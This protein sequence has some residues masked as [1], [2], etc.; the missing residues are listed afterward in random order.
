MNYTTT[1]SFSLSSLQKHTPLGALIFLSCFLFGINSLTAQTADFTSDIT[2]DCNTATVQFSDQSTGA[3]S[4]LWNLG[5][6]NTSTLQNPSATYLTP[7]TYTVSLTINGGCAGCTETKTDYITVHAPPTV[8]FSAGDTV[9]CAPYVVAFTDAS[10][11][12]GSGTIVSWD[13]D[14]G[15]GVLSTDQNPTHVYTFANT[16]DVTLSVTDNFGCQSN[17]S[18]LNYIETFHSPTAGFSLDAGLG[19]DVPHTVNF[20]DESIIPSLPPPPG[21][22]VS[23][24][25]DFGDGN[26][27]TSASPSHTYTSFGSYTVTL[28]VTSADGCTDTLTMADA[29]VIVNDQ[30]G[31]TQSST[32][33][34]PGDAVSFTDT[35]SNATAWSW[36]FGDGT[37]STD[38]NPTHIYTTSGTY[39]VALSVTFA[40]GC[41]KTYTETAAVTVFPD[42]TASFSPD[43]TDACSVPFTVNFTNSV[44]AAS[45]LWDF[46]DGNTSTDAN[47]SHTYT[48]PG[49]YDVSLTVTSADGCTHTLT[50][51]ELIQI[52]EPQAVIT[53]DVW[54]GCVPLAVS[55]TDNSTSTTPIT[56]W[57]W[58]FGDG[59]TSTAQNPSNTFT[60]D[61]QY[62][63]TLTVTN[64]EGCTSTRT[65]PAFIHAGDEPVTNFTIG[66]GDSCRITPVNF[67]NL[68]TNID[69]SLWDFGDGGTS[70]QNSPTYTYS[71]VGTFDVTL[72]TYHHGCPNTVTI[73]N[74]VQILPPDAGFTIDNNVECDFPADVVFTNTSTDATSYLWRFGDGNTST[75]T[76]PSHTYVNPGSYTVWLIAMRSN[77]NCVDSMS[78][79]VHVS[80]SIPGFTVDSD[81]GC[82]PLVATFTDTSFTTGT[83]VAWDWDF[84][85]G[86]TS[87]DQNP[88]HTYDLPGVFTVTLTI[89]EEHG[90]TETITKINYI[91]TEGPIVNFSSS[92]P[93]V[94]LGNTI[95]FTDLTVGTTG[96]TNWLWDFGDG[97]TS[98]DQNPTHTYTS[99]GTYTVSL[100]VDDAFGCDRSHTET[101]FVVVTNPIAD[102]STSDTIY[103][104]GMTIGFQNNSTG[105]G[106]SYLWDFGDGTT[107]TATS[108]THTY[109]ADGTYAVSLTVTDSYGC[110]DVFTA[111]VQNVTPNADFTAAATVL[112]CAP[113]SA[114]F[115][116]NSSSDINQWFWQ[117]GDGGVSLLENPS[118]L[119]AAPGTY[120]VTLIAFSAGGCT[121][122]IVK[123]SFITVDGPIG[124]FTYTPDS[125]CINTDVMFVADTSNVSNITWDFGDG[126]TTNVMEDSIT[127]TY[128]TVGIFY[129]QLIL[130]NSNGCVFTYTN[131]SIITSSD[132]IADFIG[133][134]SLICFGGTVDFT[135]LSSLTDA[136]YPITQWDWDFGNGDTDTLQNS[137]STYNTPGSYDVSLA[138]ETSFGCKDTMVKPLYINVIDTDIAAGFIPSSTVLCPGDPITFTDTTNTT[139]GSVISWN[140]DFGDGSTSTA[141]NGAHAFSTGGDYTITLVAGDSLCL[142]TST[143]NINVVQLNADF[144]ADDTCNFR[145]LSTNFTDQSTGDSTIVSWQWDFGYN[146][147]TS[148][149]QNPSHTFD[150][151]A[152]Y[153]ITLIVTDT[154]GCSDTLTRPAY[155]EAKNNYPIGVNDTTTAIEDNGPITITVVDDDS[156]PDGDSLIVSSIPTPPANGT[157]TVNPDGTISYEPD[158]DFFGMD[159]LQYIVCDDRDPLCDTAWIFVYVSPVDDPPVLNPQTTDITTPEDNPTTFCLDLIN[160][161]APLDPIT[162]ITQVAGY[163][164]FGSITI[165]NDSCFTYS[166]SLHYYG[167]DTVMVYICDSTGNCD[168]SAIAIDVTPVNDPPIASNDTTTTDEDTPIDINILSNDDDPVEDDSLITTS[169]ITQPVNGTVSINPD[170]T[171]NYDPDPHFF[172]I[173][174][175]QYTMCDDG[176]PMAE[177]DDAWVFITIDPVDDAPILTSSTTNLTTPEDNPIS[178]C[179]DLINLDNPL[180][181][182]TGI[183]QS[184]GPSFGSVTID[185]DSC[186]TY[187]PNLHY[188]GSDAVSFYICD[189]TGNCDTT[190]ISIDVTPVNDPPIASND[191][192]TT[193]EDTPIDINI[194]GNDDDPVEDDSLITTSIITGPVNGTASINPDG[195]I[196][197]D[198]NPDFF[199]IDSLHY[200]MCDDGTPIAECDDAWVFITVD[201]VDDAPVITP[202]TASLTTP[203]D[204]PLTVALTVTNPDFPLDA[205]TSITPIGGTTLFGTVTIIDDT[206]FTYTPNLHYYGPDTVAVYVCD[207]TGNCDTA[208]VAIDVT[209][210]NDP[211]I[212]VNDTTQTLVDIP[213][214]IDVLG[215]DS[216][217]VEGDSLITNLVLT[218][219]LNGTASI[220]P[221]GTINYVPDPGYHGLDS[222]Q[223]IM[224]DDGT[225][226]LCDTAWVLITI[227][228][229]NPPVAVNDSI[230]VTEDTPIDYPILTN[231]SDPNPGD[232]IFPTNIITDPVHGTASINPDG[233]INYVPATN[234]FGYDS[235]QYVIC[236]DGTPVMCDTAWLLISVDDVDDDPVVIPSDTAITLPEDSVHM[237]C[238][239]VFNFDAPMD[240]ITASN[241][242]GYPQNGIIPFVNDS[243]TNYIPNPDYFGPDTIIILAC[244]LS[245][246]C[247]T[248]TVYV[249]VTPVNDP[250]TAVND[251]TSTDEDVSID[252]PVLNNDHNQYETD[253]IFVTNVSVAPVNGTATVNPDGSI[254]YDPFTGFFGID[255]L[256]YTI[257]DDQVP[258]LCT[259]AWAFITIDS[260]DYLPVA[261][262]DTVTVYEG[263]VNAIIQPLLNDTDANGDSTISILAINPTPVHGTISLNPDSTFSYTP[264]PNFFGIDSLQY[265]IVD[266]QGNT[267]TAWVL[268]NVLG[269]DD[270]PVAS[271]D[272]VW[273]SEDDGAV[274]IPILANDYDIDGDSLLISSVSPLPQNG[275]A[276]VN[277]NGTISYTPDPNFHGVDSLMYVITDDYATGSSDTAWVFIYVASVND[278]IIAVN[279]TT[280]TDEDTPVVID[281]LVNDSD[282][283]DGDSLMVTNILIGA[284]NGNVVINPDGTTTYTPNPNFAGV[285]S[286]TYIVTDT[287]NPA[288]DDTAVVYITINPVND[289]PVAVDDAVTTDEDTP[290]TISVLDNDDDPIDGDS[291]MTSSILVGPTNG[292]VVINPDGTTTYTPNPNYNGTDTFTYVITDVNGLTDTAVVVITIDP[293]ND[294]PVAVDN[295]TT[296]DEDTPV[297]ID[298]LANDDD[299]DGD[300]ISTTSI[301][302]GPANGSVVINPDGTTTYTP[303][304]NY[305]GTDTFTYV[306][307][308]TDGLTDTAIVV[309]TITPSNDPP[310]AVDNA[311]TTDEDTPVTIDV[312]ANDSDV[313]GDSIFT[314]SILV[315]PTNGNVVINPDGTT[316]YTP[317]P[318]YTGTDTFTYVITD[319]H[320]LTDTAVVVVTIDPVNDPPV[321]LDNASTTDEDT[322]VTIDV[323]GNDSDVDGDTISTASILVGPTNGS[324]VIN[325]D[326]T[327]TYTPNPNYTGTDTFT[328]VITDTDGLTDTAVVVVT[329]DPVNDPPVAVDNAGTTDEDTPIT[330]DV[331]ANDDDVD[332]DSIFTSS[333]LVGPANGS[334]V[335]NPDGT[336]TYTPDPNYTGTDTFTYVITATDGLTDTAIVVITIDP[337]NDPPVAVDNAS[338]TDEDT[339]VTIDV[340][341]N[342][343]DVDGDTISTATILVG[344]TNGSVVINPDGTTTYTPNPNY[345]GTD[346][347]TYVI[348]DTDG[349]TDTA[350]VVVTIDPANDPPVA[351]DDATTTDEDTPVTIDVL[352]NDSDVDGDSISTASILAGPTNGSVVINPDGTTTYTPNPNYNGTDTFTYVITDIHGLTDTAVVVITIDPVNDPPVAVDNASTTD[353]DTPVT[354]DVLANDDDVD[355]DSISTTSVLVGPTNGSVVINPDGTTTYTPNANYTGTDTFTYVITATDGL[356]DTAVVVVTINPSNDPPVAVDN[357]TTTDEDTP[358]TIDV[359]ANDSDVDGDSISTASILVGPTN[360]SVVINPD[361]T[362]TYTPD[363]NYN[364]T[365]TFTYVITDIHGLTDTAVVVITIDPV[366]DPPVAV[367]NAATTDE[368]TPVVI[369]VLANDDD[370]DGDSISTT[371]ILV[372]PTNGSVVINPDGTTTY[373]PNPHY[374]GTDTFTYV[375]TATDGLMD[376]AVV[377]VTIDPS[378]DPPVATDD[379]VSTDEDTP[380]VIDV[381]VNDSDVDGDSIMVG[382][383]LSNPTNGVLTTNPD[384]TL[385][386][387]PDPNFTGTD[388]FTYIVRDTDGLI[389]TAVVV[390]TV[391]PSNDP[392]VAVD[393]ATTT[394][395]DTPVTIDILANDYDI[396]GDTV[397]LGAILSGPSNGTL[398]TNPD[399]TVTYTPDPNF[400]GTD[401]FTYI[402]RDPDGLID[403]AVV[404]ITVDPSNDPP[405]AVNDTTV[406]D[407]DTPVVIDILADDYDVDGDSIALHGLLS[408]PSN[409]SLG[410]NPDGTITYTP[411]PNFT[412]SD[413]FSYIIVDEDGL[414]DTA[415]VL[416]SVNP[417]NDPPVAVN[418][419]A[420][421]DE[422]TPVVIDVLA[423]DDDVD[424]DSISTTSIH[425]APNNGTASINPDGT[426]TYTPNANYTGSD[427]FTYIITDENGDTDTAVVVVTIDPSNDPPVAVNDTVTTDLNTAITIDALANDSDPI[428]GDSL[429]MTTIL[430]GANNG[431]TS[432]NPDGTV[433]YTP[434]NGFTGIDSLEYL[435]CDNGSPSQCTNAWIFITVN[436]TNTP[437]VAHNDINNTLVNTPVTGSVLQNDDDDNGTGNLTA[438]LVTSPSNGTI[439]WNPDGTYTYVPNTDFVGTDCFDYFITDEDGLIDTATICI[440]VTDPAADPPVANDDYTVTYVDTPIPGNVMHNDF[441]VDGDLL[442]VGTTLISGPQNGTVSMNPDG[443]FIYTPD[444]G[445]VGIDTFTYVLF[446]SQA[447]GASDTAT[448]IILV[449]DT[450]NGTTNLPPFAG[451]DANIT[452]VNTP[453]TG[454][455]LPNDI[456]LDGTTLTVNQTPIVQPAHGTVTIDAN[457]NYTYT[458][459]PDYTGPDFFVYEVCD[460]GTPQ[461]CRQATVYITVLP[462]N[463]V[464]PV[465]YL[466]FTAELEG[467]DAFLNWITATEIN[468]DYFAI[469]RSTDGISFERVGVENAA[470]TTTE[471]TSYLFID[472]NVTNLGTERVYYRLKQV[473]FDGTF[474]Y[475][476]TIELTLPQIEE[477]IQSNVYPNP[478]SDYVYVTAQTQEAT[479]LKIKLV[480]MS[481]QLVWEY[482]TAEAS[483]ATQVEIPLEQF[484]RGMYFIQ[485]VSP[486][487]TQTHK[488]IVE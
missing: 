36:D 158:P 454:A 363:P 205:V 18:Q 207:S 429:M 1:V 104:T 148:T 424:G 280:V 465:E 427:I 235:L 8:D 423:N 146:N 64:A 184:A 373:T 262:N 67:T 268:I 323:L 46:G 105:D 92:S 85:D 12:A 139:Y 276:V 383:I 324:V 31:F 473:D 165:D 446:E 13:W 123:P 402:V 41:V 411:N 98:T 82:A 250:P 272:T 107:S 309:V 182:I 320:G 45:Y 432:I 178:F 451:D 397:M 118:N 221:D 360:G 188:N 335:I 201:P 166:P 11:A 331:L 24:S 9:G 314:S 218:D 460:N 95:T 38:Q 65:F 100:T 477:E 395:E 459:N 367:D 27:S 434:D 244:D 281:V 185:N 301:L 315:G 476:N 71:T 233:T 311:S 84:G 342:D 160:V 60:A 379:A 364:G 77:G 42:I 227:N 102:F 413:S 260:V 279:D 441:D 215:S 302:V 21:V 392:P 231:D 478:A 393:N 20:S 120:D 258:S 344:P 30:P 211:P 303:N 359:L 58:D 131:D 438:N 230:A 340:L 372:G 53:S 486:R 405:V 418:D 109:G 299:V 419:A 99:D 292:S 89:T 232:I 145:P 237:V 463:A 408:P 81:S 275:T 433:T 371:N 263:D 390:I 86:N 374:T 130:E 70:T 94:C 425:V 240:Q 149:T 448:V 217:P 375:I 343:S 181:P 69:S 153:D 248:A 192:T 456:D 33:A 338:T 291:I 47:P 307:T 370:V 246:D 138:I 440:D 234:Y 112:G 439:T 412:G 169:I 471:S 203:E 72:T 475:S 317:D 274:A 206:T 76:S 294:P 436:A 242:A 482:K 175:L 297:T 150:S 284:T 161:D 212:A 79:M 49:L 346:T 286:F 261:N 352:L 298:V 7:G 210:V 325:P 410:I 159:S 34:C 213:I 270:P 63:V 285:D 48:A 422:D 155:V 52:I 14:F 290:I 333:I 384:G 430:V 388:T 87:T 455:I 330:I 247:D 74:G 10:T 140:W 417:D 358:V 117:F 305:T 174:S 267:D 483:T 228:L 190:T 32:T 339:P 382:A 269:T 170:G 271:N 224:C 186:F 366:N 222:L 329:I 171:I 6:G 199:G 226:N 23:W 196:N 96:L 300:S 403:T 62:D 78:R 283:I 406:T 167:P 461:E 391:D 306:I 389:D 453:V 449:L 110:T 289:P 253:S 209:P 88:T 66:Q 293:V 484:A 354:I 351:V 310:V 256:E 288:L 208:V 173:D 73:G 488:L 452:D 113:E 236:D 5:N 377:V 318:N 431:M 334:V 264:N 467:R 2:S 142:D 229:N 143:F 396:D 191:T 119:Y 265:V 381:L 485:V 394:D 322:P 111:D 480:N 398:T 183:M 134:D 25:W 450:P 51:D 350:V 332:G 404:T 356:T 225:P 319:I 223:Y 163:P 220:N 409:G 135:D 54:N 17:F 37:T 277:P 15:D 194:L 35:S 75:A 466:A 442:L 304:A 295:A 273:I 168:T 61:G 399:G 245:G 187:T 328:Y 56:S 308:A 415:V 162:G 341:G 287:G 124:N 239:D 116:D 127:H 380:V 282:P 28:V 202:S 266:P 126:T 40:N 93:N 179:L 198:P 156:D 141:Q 122:T 200:T 378:N 22:I 400:T 157:A 91:D 428:E 249:T 474:S 204:N 345:T 144:M 469:E 447:N 254:H 129:P 3:G 106:I 337:V 464:F 137:T 59:N 462:A 4:W 357:A 68:T 164:S 369:D 321:A 172:G 90:C 16:F 385:T 243:C 348:T 133:I 327:T 55:F 83:I 151:I 365:D 214:D 407:E 458:P 136:T 195:T 296:T 426:V 457:G 376:T 50:Q 80:R 362:T 444:P 108:P 326:G 470:G 176:T 128:T 349:L 238:F 255:S 437:P 29:V 361:G 216:D 101:D 125:G 401:V 421:T 39:D 445:F 313:D 468:N 115:I 472:E 252:I 177:C 278:D 241:V 19:C 57:L 257:C 121:D 197:Y 312:L 189:S 251:T 353:E 368:D 152:A 479:K 114:A 147:Q 487:K 316:T 414:L 132:P 355:G 416:I 154:Y 180:D 347:F 97:N 193:D 481:G 219:P 26:T 43:D 259:T 386:Y 443:T 435:V 103:C 420:T 44:A 387:T 336:T